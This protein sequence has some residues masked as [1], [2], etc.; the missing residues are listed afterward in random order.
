MGQ[1]TADLRSLVHTGPPHEPLATARKTTRAVVLRHAMP[2][3]AWHHDLLLERLPSSAQAANDPDDRRLI[4]FR[5]TPP[6]HDPAT[7]LAGATRLADHRALYLDHEG[8]LTRSRGH[9][10]RL[11]TGSITALLESTD[12]LSASITFPAARVS[13]TASRTDDD[14]WRLELMWAPRP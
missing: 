1:T 10:R 6:P 13:L 3:G 4:A 11:A 8:P 14:R 5:V 9:V 12:D 7:A 2:D